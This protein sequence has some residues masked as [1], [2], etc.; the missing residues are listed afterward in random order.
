MFHTVATDGEYELDEFYRISA[1]CNLAD[2][3]VFDRLTGTG[4]GVDRYVFRLTSSACAGT[5]RT[6]NDGHARLQPTPRRPGGGALRRR[7]VDLPLEF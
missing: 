4:Q 7:P 3:D 2:G 6:F 5:L 1:G